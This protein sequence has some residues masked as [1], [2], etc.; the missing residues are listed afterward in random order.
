MDNK[1]NNQPFKVDAAAALR[2]DG[3][4]GE[5]DCECGLEDEVDYSKVNRLSLDPLIFTIFI[6]SKQKSLVQI[7]Q[8]KTV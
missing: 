8:H 4:A 1:R 6:H 7:G 3:E 5:G 2:R